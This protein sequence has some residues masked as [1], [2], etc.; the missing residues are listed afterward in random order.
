MAAYFIRQYYLWYLVPSGYTLYYRC[1]ACNRQTVVPS[2]GDLVG[3][4]WL[5]VVCGPA[6]FFILRWAYQTRG[7]QI[8]VA[9]VLGTGFLIFLL[10]YS[11][12][13]LYLGIRNRRDFPVLK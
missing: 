8:S 1:R 10:G 13:N 2:I 5:V 6:L 4:S 11:L 7:Q 9:G 12:R 3:S